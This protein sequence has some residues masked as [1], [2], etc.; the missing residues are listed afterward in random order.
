M[1]RSICRRRNRAACADER[2]SQ[3]PHELERVVSRL[4]CSRARATP[5]ACQRSCQ[6]TWR[7]RRSAHHAGA[8]SYEHELRN[9]LRSVAH[10]WLAAGARSACGRARRSTQR[11]RYPRASARALAVTRCGC[12]PSSRRLERVRHRRYLLSGQ[13]GP[14]GSHRQRHRGRARLQQLRYLARHRVCR[15]LPHRAVAHPA[16]RRRRIMADARRALE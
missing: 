5:S 7:S 8:G 4:A 14:Q 3:P 13:R 1:P 12:V 9:V 10:P 6:R 11:C 15:R 16:R 2:C